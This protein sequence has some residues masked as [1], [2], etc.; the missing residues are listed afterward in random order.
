MSNIFERLKENN[1]LNAN[2]EIIVEYL[3]NHLDEI[4][5]ISS[6]EFARRTYTSSTSIIRFIKKLKYKS[7]TD[8]RLHIVSD[9]KNM[10]NPIPSIQSNEDMITLVNKISEIETSIIQKTK[11][12]ISIETLHKVMILINQYQYIDIIA[13][14]TNSTIAEY[15][16]HLLWSVGKIATVYHNNNKQLLL[17]LNIPKDH[18]VILISKSGKNPYIINTAK[19]L[20]ERGV[21][22]IALTSSLDEGLAKLCLYSLYGL[23]ETSSEKL[24]D[25]VF[26]ISINCIIHLIYA[27]LFSQNYESTLE[28]EKL[29]IELF[30]KNQKI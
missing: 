2:E 14:D 29:Y 15:A 17:G 8:F 12:T 13:T 18:I 3:I 16:S 30:N 5:Y 26:F 9:L 21:K 6:G 1:H 24:K 27:I 10:K 20:K 25:A 4:P 22:T 23:S 28:L 7:Y 19:T 11:E